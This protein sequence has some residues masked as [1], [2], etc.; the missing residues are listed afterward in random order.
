MTSPWVTFQDPPTLFVEPPPD[1]EWPESAQDKD[2]DPAQPWRLRKYDPNSN[3]K[4]F[5]DD[6]VQQWKQLGVPGGFIRATATYDQLVRFADIRQTRFK[7]PPTQ[8]GS[9]T[10]VVLTEAEDGKALQANGSSSLRCM[11]KCYADILYAIH[12]EGQIRGDGNGGWIYESLNELTDMMRHFPWELERLENE[13]FGGRSVNNKLVPGFE[14]LYPFGQHI[15]EMTA[16][17]QAIV[18]WAKEVMTD[19]MQHFHQVSLPF[20]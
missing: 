9:N 13:R 4:G 14:W 10:N 3:G 1:D 17:L 16:N 15:H 20:S 2:Y 5:D 18:T 8:D 19:P 11:W 12:R 7:G 6:I